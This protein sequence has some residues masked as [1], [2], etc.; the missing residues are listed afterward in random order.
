MIH[1]VH[2]A[3]FRSLMEIALKHYGYEAL[4]RELNCSKPTLDKWI[5]G[6]SKPA[7]GYETLIR[8]NLIKITGSYLS[9][10]MILLPSI[11]KFREAAYKQITNNGDYTH[12]VKR[13][14]CE[15]NK[16]GFDSR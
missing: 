11:K 10:G 14:L 7:P 12:P 3:P 5:A 9:G 13:L 2:I 1:P 4:A 8:E 16:D 15:S 6:E